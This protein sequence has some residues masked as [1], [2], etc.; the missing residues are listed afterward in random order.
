MVVASTLSDPAANP[1][2]LPAG[3][4]SRTLRH[5]LFGT[6]K[7]FDEFDYHAA[8]GV[9]RYN[10]VTQQTASAQSFIRGDLKTGTRIRFAMTAIAS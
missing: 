6:S 1:I 2:Y 10:V 5:A 7:A 3:Q 8:I 9:A 4:R